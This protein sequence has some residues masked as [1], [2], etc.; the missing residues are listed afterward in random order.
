MN[1]KESLFDDMVNIPP[2][3]IHIFKTTQEMDQYGLLQ[4][5]PVTAEVVA[6][7]QMKRYA[8]ASKSE[9]HERKR[10]VEQECS[11]LQSNQH[12]DCLERVMKGG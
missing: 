12:I 6:N 11:R 2:E 7:A 10:K 4:L 1:V 8:I 5:D 3:N 9:F